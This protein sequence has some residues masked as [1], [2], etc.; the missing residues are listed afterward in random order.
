MA[1]DVVEPLWRNVQRT[2]Q[3]VSLRGAYGEA[4]V[5]PLDETG[6]ERVTGG[7]VPDAGHRQLL[8]QTVLERAVGSLH[9]TLHLAG[10]DARDLDVQLG[11]RTAELGH[12]LASLRISIGPKHGVLVRVRRD[13]AAVPLHIGVQ[14][15]KYEAVLALGRSAAA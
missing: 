1:Q 12:A 14:T 13:R 8:H 11:Q 5:E 10:V 7:H 2:M 3:V 15:S 4:F 6:Q 9:A